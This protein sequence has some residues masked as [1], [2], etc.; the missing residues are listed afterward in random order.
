MNCFA[1]HMRPLPPACPCPPKTGKI[2][3]T[4]LVMKKKKQLL[5]RVN[6]AGRQLLFYVHASCQNF[7]SEFLSEL[8][9]RNH[10][11]KELS[12]DRKGMIHGASSL[13]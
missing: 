6:T 13:S 10:S 5:H 3:Y 8:H 9:V 12:L 11:L 7:M 1:V 4:G 2:H